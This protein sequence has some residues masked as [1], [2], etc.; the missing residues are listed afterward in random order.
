M[1]EVFTVYGPHSDKESCGGC[2]RTLWTE[3]A[4]GDDG[5]SNSPMCACGL[6]EETGLHIIC[7]CTKFL[8]LRRR[9][10]ATGWLHPG[11]FP[12]LDLAFC[13]GPLR[14]LNDLNDEPEERTKSVF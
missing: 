11:R 4:L 5:L 13:T 12:I 2:N 1:V 7:E 8:T 6:S 9:T 3:Q 14:G 10:W